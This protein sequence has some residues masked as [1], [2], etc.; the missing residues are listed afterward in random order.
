MGILRTALVGTAAYQIGKKAFKDEEKKEC[1]QSNLTSPQPYYHPEYPPQYQYGQP[2]YG[3][4]PYGQ[5]PYDQNPY[6]QNPYGQNPYGQ[7][8]S[9]APQYPQGYGNNHQ[10]YPPQQSNQQYSRGT[11]DFV[12]NGGPRSMKASPPSYQPNP[13]YHQSNEKSPVHSQGQENYSHGRPN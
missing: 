7:N 1:K 5:N 9:G 6:G 2:P 4:P 3:Q 12:S 13:A 8:P 10:G 11:E